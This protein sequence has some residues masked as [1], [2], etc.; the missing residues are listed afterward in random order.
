MKLKQILFFP[1]LFL[2][3]ACYQIGQEKDNQNS[4]SEIDKL[5]IKDTVSSFPNNESNGKVEKGL[6][7]YKEYFRKHK[8]TFTKKENEI[9]NLISSIP[10]VN[11]ILDDRT[12]QGNYIN[13]NIVADSSK[14]E[15]AFYEV[16]GDEYHFAC[17]EIVFIF[18]VNPKTMEIKNYRMSTEELISLDKWKTDYRKATA[19]NSAQAQNQAV[20]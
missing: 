17:N 11:S 20:R 5:K 1:C 12:K 4:I 9:L 7:E 10:E 19:C 13:L 18:H 3:A 16:W 14:N 8:L 15:G 6:V 2:L